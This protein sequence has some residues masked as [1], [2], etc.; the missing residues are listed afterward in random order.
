VRLPEVSEGFSYAPQ[1]TMCFSDFV[2]LVPTAQ[3]F[4]CGVRATSRLEG[5]GYKSNICQSRNPSTYLRCQYRKD[6]Y[7]QGLTKTTLLL[8]TTTTR[9]GLQEASRQ[10]VA[11]DDL[12]AAGAPSRRH[13]QL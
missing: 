4:I 5:L 8:H 12:L 11:H 10:D 1:L 2:N 3:C 9:A 7:R 13:R 6:Y